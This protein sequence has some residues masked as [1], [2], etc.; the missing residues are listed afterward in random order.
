MVGGYPMTIIRFSYILWLRDFRGGW[1]I[2]QNE[3]KESAMMEGLEW[4][5]LRGLEIIISFFIT[6]CFERKEKER[7][8]TKWLREGEGET[9]KSWG[10]VHVMGRGKIKMEGELVNL[11]SINWWD[12]QT[13]SYLIG[14]HVPL[15]GVLPSR[16]Q[17]K[18]IKSWSTRANRNSW[19]LKMSLH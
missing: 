3:S 16:D 6:P 12:K 8:E 7:K 15:K 14:G 19:S 11:W 4:C 1:S 2:T 17:Q 10:C 9:K 18:L 13:W 5:D